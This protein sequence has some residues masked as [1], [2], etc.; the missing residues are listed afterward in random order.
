MHLV[1]DF[2]FERLPEDEPLIMITFVTKTLCMTWLGKCDVGP[3]HPE[4][5][6]ATGVR[7]QYAG[8]RDGDQEEPCLTYTTRYFLCTSGQESLFKIHSGVPSQ[9]YSGVRTCWD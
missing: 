8:F 9:C 2:S 4:D 1:G 3:L 5:E 6:E 7:L